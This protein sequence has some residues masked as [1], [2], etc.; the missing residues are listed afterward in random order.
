MAPPPAP[1]PAPAPGSPAQRPR[2]TSLE[3][4]ARLP[5]NRECADCGAADPEWASVNL[6]VRICIACAGTHRSLGAHISKVKSL[7]LDSWKPD[8][9]QAFAAPGGNAEVNR[10]LAARPPPSGTSRAEMDRYIAAKYRGTAPSQQGCASAAEG[11]GGDASGAAP[12]QQGT[13]CHSGLVIADILGVELTAERARELRLLGPLFLQLT[14]S[15]A[16][17]PV[18]AEPTDPRRG[19]QSVSWE[20]PAR[21]QLLWDTEDPDRRFLS[22]RVYDGGSLGGEPSLA[23]EGFV[24]L[25]EL[26]KTAEGVATPWTLPLRVPPEGDDELDDEDLA[27]A[28]DQLPECGEARLTLTIVDMSNLAR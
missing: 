3:E 19:S 16:L 6:G 24:D 9:V 4:Q 18:T 21:R 23:A 12:S 25:V 13:T 20:P 10:R 26:A 11:S 27:D 1:A 28:A 5:G 8:E 14:V 2:P 7:T 15:L 17:G 22:C